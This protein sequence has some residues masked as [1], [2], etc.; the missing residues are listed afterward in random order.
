MTVNNKR[1]IEIL[2]KG[3]TKYKNHFAV[4]LL[5]KEGNVALPNNKPLA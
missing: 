4:G 3:T 5:S 2:Q 1:V